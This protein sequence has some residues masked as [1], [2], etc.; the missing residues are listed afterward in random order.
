MRICCVSGCWWRP[1]ATPQFDHPHP[2]SRR[3]LYEWL[4]RAQAALGAESAARASWERATQITSSRSHQAR[5][6]TRI[7]ESFAR[8]GKHGRAAEAYRRIWTRYPEQAEADSAA[9]ELDGLERTLGRPYRD[10]EHTLERGRTLYKRRRNE[11]ALAAFEGAIALGL[12]PKQTTL[13]E[14]GRA[15]SLFRL[16]RY[17]EA[18]K[19]YDAL[20]YTE[21]RRIQRSRAYARS[22]Q[23]PRGAKDLEALGRESR[24]SQGTRALLIAALLWDG[25]GAWTRAAR[26]YRRILK[27]APRSGAAES[28]RWRLGWEAYRGERYEEA[29][30][31]FEKLE[32]IEDDPI[33]ALRPRYWTLRARERLGDLEALTGFQALAQEYP[34]TYYG[35]RSAGRVAPR[36]DLPPPL[37]ES[38]PGGAVALQ[39]D[40]L[41]RAQILVEAGLAEA[42]RSELALLRKRAKG[43]DDRLSLAQLHAEIGDFNRAQRLVIDHYGGRLSRGPAARHIDL[44]WHAWPAPFEGAIRDL[45]GQGV[46]LDPALL[47]SIMREESGYRPEVISV[48]GARGLLQLMPTTADRVARDIGMPDFDPDHLFQP[49]VN[50]RLGAAYL[51]SLLAQFDGRHSAA[52]ASYNAGPQAVSRWLDAH[53]GEDDEFVE[54]IPYSQTRAYAKRVLR[55]FH[56]YR[57]LH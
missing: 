37:I 45:R 39:S 36:P 53:I 50:I 14:S 46:S 21:E 23:V 56:A 24:T 19:A 35:W 49:A 5:L 28:A 40:D 8:S 52:I 9:R 43:L 30:E 12:S 16:R 38:I 1:S 13:A 3:E 54:E 25:E 31:H 29:I 42:A 47:Y 57:V 4:G 51:E 55:S 33:V 6:H 41:A 18:A 20:P 7:A 11:A 17:P 22:G 48:S 44:W 34:F 10:A 2:P 27:R 26:L 15:E 32:R